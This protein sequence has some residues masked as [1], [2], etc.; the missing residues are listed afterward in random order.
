[1]KHG[2]VFCIGI[3]CSLTI[4]AQCAMCKAVVTNGEQQSNTALAEGINS[5]IIYLMGIPY[6]LMA[7]AAFF[8]FRKQ[9]VSFFKGTNA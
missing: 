2:L 8:M 3:L 1:M 9:I 7:T 5:G 6:L 4:Q